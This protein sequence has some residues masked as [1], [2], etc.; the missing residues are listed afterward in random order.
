MLVAGSGLPGP[1]LL[2]FGSLRVG[3]DPYGGLPHDCPIEP[4]FNPAGCAMPAY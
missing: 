4:A 3:D 2:E 1:G